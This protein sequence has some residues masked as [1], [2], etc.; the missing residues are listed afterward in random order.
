MVEIARSKAKD[1][2]S[3][4]FLQADATR[5]ELVEEYDASIAMYGVISYFV[6]DAEL[7]SLLRSARRALKPG[8]VFVFDTWNLI[9]IHGKK[10]Y[11]E[12]PFASFR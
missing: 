12:T 11:Y 5:L 3:V 6:S 9:G 7:L 2:P 10:V 1:L 4:S 8:S